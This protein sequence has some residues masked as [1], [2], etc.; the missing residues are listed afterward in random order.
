MP[1]FLNMTY[2][3]ECLLHS[4]ASTLRLYHCSSFYLFVLQVNYLI[5]SLCCR[6]EDISGKTFSL[7]DERGNFVTKAIHETDLAKAE[8]NGQRLASGLPDPPC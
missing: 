1:H 8:A 3:P 5:G 7:Y 2:M 6:L 4:A